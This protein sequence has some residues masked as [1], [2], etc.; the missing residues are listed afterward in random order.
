MFSC[1]EKTRN[2]SLCRMLLILRF[3][4]TIV[5]YVRYF[6][7][8]DRVSTNENKYTHPYADPDSKVHMT[9][10]RVTIVDHTICDTET[11]Q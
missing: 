4:L 3:I 1:I 7:F 9:G 11:D 2:A 10:P 5:K 8:T 6:M